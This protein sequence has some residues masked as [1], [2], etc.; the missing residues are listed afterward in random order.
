MA[1]PAKNMELVHVP[2]AV[3]C[4]LLLLSGDVEQNPGPVIRKGE[5]EL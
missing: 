5:I 1:L 2:A 3:V 4:L